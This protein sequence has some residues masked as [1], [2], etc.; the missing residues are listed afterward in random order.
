[1]TKSTVKIL[2]N[3]VLSDQFYVL[4]RYTFERVERGGELVTQARE[5]YDRGNG[6]AILLYNRAAQTV[7]PTRQF[8]DA[9]FCEWAAIQLGC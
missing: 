5:V 7:I 4:R 8:L 2:E 1:M 9:D 6:A 3:R